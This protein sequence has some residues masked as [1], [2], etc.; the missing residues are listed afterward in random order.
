MPPVFW[1]LVSRD[2]RLLES[3]LTAVPK[4]L[5]S[6]AIG[7]DATSALRP[8]TEALPSDVSAGVAD[9]LNGPSA[10]MKRLIAGACAPRSS[11]TGDISS[12][13]APRRT[14]VGLSCRRNGG[15]HGI[16]FSERTPLPAR[17]PGRVAGL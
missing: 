6:C 11:S 7:L 15:E 3:G 4:V 13:S 12:D 17:A 9:L 10:M 5:R 1:K 16:P 14:I 8:T 2:A